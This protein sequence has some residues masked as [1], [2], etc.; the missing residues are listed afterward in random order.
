MKSEEIRIKLESIKNAAEKG[1]KALLSEL[2][3]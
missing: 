2:S 3:Q 1:E